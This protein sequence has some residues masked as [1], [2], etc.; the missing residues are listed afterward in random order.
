MV[1]PLTPTEI[2]QVNTLAA[3]IAAQQ[4]ITPQ[5]ALNNYAKSLGY[6]FGDLDVWMGRPAG[7]SLNMAVAAGIEPAPSGNY[8]PVQPTPTP[9]PAPT[10]AP[11]P[12]PTP[13]PTPAPTPTPTPAP[14]PTPAPT[15][16][17]TPAPA[18]TNASVS[19][20]TAAERAEVT[21]KAT[22]LAQAAN[23]PTTPEYEL[24]KF[25]RENGIPMS[26]LD[27][28][29]G[30]GQGTTQGWAL[31]NIDLIKQYTPAAQQPLFNPTINVPPTSVNNIVNVPQSAVNNTI[32][33]PQGPA[34][35]VNVNMPTNPTV[36]ALSAAEQQSVIKQATEKAQAA[37]TTPEYELYKFAKDSGID[38]T[39][40]D[41]YMGWDR[42][43]TQGW[44]LQNRDAINTYQAKEAAAKAAADKAASAP[45]PVKPLDAATRASVIQQ[46][47]AIAGG[48]PGMTPEQALY[49]YGKTNSI[50]DS[51][52][53]TYMGW[54][55]GTTAAWALKTAQP[56][57]IKP[58]D[59]ATRASVVQQAQAVAG[60]K[61]IAPEQALYDYGRANNIK[62]VDMDTYMGW[63]AGTTSAWANKTQQ[64]DPIKTV[65]ALTSSVSA[66][67]AYGLDPATRQSIIDQ[68]K[69]IAAQQ[70][71]TPERAL[72]NYADANKIG[73]QDVDTYM[74]WGPG[75]TQ[76][77]ATNNVPG[78]T[79]P[80]GAQGTSQVA[81]LATSQ[82]APLATTQVAPLSTVPPQPMYKLPVLNSLYQNQQQRMTSAP[83][84]FNFQAQQT[85]QVAP[86]TTQQPG[87]LTN[88]I[89]NT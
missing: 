7:Q 72:Y 58:L 61:G 83:P 73:V 48:T 77:W 16:T 43:T 52:M 63:P 25:S 15:P 76:Y 10:P 39:D 49:N 28:Y 82:V 34:P 12:T 19:P 44:A 5:Q 64:P 59:A 30:W 85:Q 70:G 68:A 84:Q 38:T 2:Q 74:G 33:V 40:V 89:S 45:A 23:P 46:A 86:L 32:N 13:T 3:Q 51:D 57:P 54:P 29:M 36:K 8:N 11:T 24:Y 47:Q 50:K 66:T 53:D 62:D 69:A 18:P 60:A 27:A 1:T 56:A 4:G 31:N 42:G 88:V 20:L 81:P 17:P 87:A 55:A 21:R 6:S 67:G 9:T 37:G 75:T 80:P 14:A 79:P 65:G 78:F 22:S 71:I 26:D 35:T 41:T